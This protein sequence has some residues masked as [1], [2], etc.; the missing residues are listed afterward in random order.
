MSD[1]DAHLDTPE[2]P[3][4]DPYS[5]LRDGNYVL[6]ALGFMCSSFGLQMMGMA[7]G[8]EMYERTGNPLWVGL[9]GLARALP[10]VLMAL[11]AGHIIDHFDRKRVL[12][13]TQTGFAVA[14]GL[15]AWASYAQA[16]K[17]LVLVLIVLA[18][19]VRTFN[20]PV[21]S[22][23]LPDLVPK[24]VFA[25]AVTW[26]SGVFQL[27]A[28]LGPLF[29]GYLIHLMDKAWVVYAITGVLCGVFAI[30]TMFMQPVHV[31][32]RA[33]KMPGMR[34][35]VRDGVRH[36]MR[37]KVI[38][39]T[40]ALDLFAVLLGGAT[41]LMP[42]Y[43]KDIL[44]VGPLGLGLLR[45]M[46]FVGAF[47]MALVLAHRPIRKAA[48]PLLLWSVAI[49]GACTIGFG[50]SRWLI[51]SL[52]CLFVLG[53]VDNISVVI[54]H[55]LVQVRTPPELRG[56]VSA[57]N[58]VFIESSNELGGFES[59]AVA[60]LFGTW[61]G[62]GVVTGATISVVSGGIGTLIVVAAVATAWPQIRKL[63]RLDEH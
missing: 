17:E 45:S 41:V 52:A 38:L 63:D 51:L 13:L 48:G 22:S 25:N 61:L 7:L 33:A 59:G 3:K 60:W 21:R 2:A 5:A 1:F 6:F 31:R 26:N 18:G 9:I 32:P 43:A 34:R 14:A 23:L 8:W 37:E 44:D 57:V 12:F 46:P 39:S 20:G 24:E 27:S 55:V 4:H 15:L 16:P 19:L 58:S 10:V 40:I 53:A 54:R 42:V 28:T 56:R 35:G 50:L 49:F 11:P 36:L 47:V 29:A 30:T 62:L